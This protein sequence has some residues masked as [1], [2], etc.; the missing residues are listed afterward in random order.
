MTM[1]EA[2]DRKKYL[3][4]GG[5]G[6]GANSCTSDDHVCKEQISYYTTVNL[7]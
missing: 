1:E 7:V 2:V 3:G 6:G 4:G 5:G